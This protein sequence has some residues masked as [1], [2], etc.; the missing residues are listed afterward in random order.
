MNKGATVILYP[1]SDLGRAKAIFTRLLDGEPLVDAPY[2]VGYEVAGQQIGL[3]PNG[4]ARGMTGAT[5]F[6]EVDDINDTV[7]S[8][9]E[10]GASIV[11]DVHPVGGGRVVAMIRDG[12]GN[13]IGL[14][15]TS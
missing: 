2:Y 11:E 10:A 5:P 4:K 3:D 9:T 13:M 6:W 14:S 1:V 7:A 8:L 12:D 15:Q